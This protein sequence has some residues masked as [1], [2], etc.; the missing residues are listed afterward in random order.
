MQ[1]NP[2]HNP[3]Q[4]HLPVLASHFCT[5]FVTHERALAFLEQA[6]YSKVPSWSACFSVNICMCNVT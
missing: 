6:W 2:N 5:S 3:H 4:P 1:T